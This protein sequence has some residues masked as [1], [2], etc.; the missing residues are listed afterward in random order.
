MSLPSTQTPLSTDLP[1]A[2]TF[3]RL[4]RREGFRVLVAIEPDGGAVQTRSFAVREESELAEWVERHNGDGENVYWTV[5]SVERPVAKKPSREDVAAMDFLHVDVDPDKRKPLDEERARIAR[6]F[7]TRPSGVPVPTLL[8]DSGGG[9][10]AFWRLESPFR[11]E[12]S[13][14]LY[15]DAKRYNQ[16]LEVLFGGDACHNVDRIMRLPGTVNWPDARKRAAGRVPRLAALLETRDVAYP[17]SA[18]TPAPRV[19]SPG[20]G[21]ALPAAR[22]ETSNVRRLLSLEEL[23]SSATGQ[24]KVVINQGRDP[25]NPNKWPSRSEPLFWVCCELIRIGVADDVIYSV[26]TDPDFGI[27]ESVLEKGA[28]SERYALQQIAHAHDHVTD[29]NLAEL[30]H[31]HAVIGDLG[32]KCRIL[33]EGRDES[34]DRP[35]LSYQSFDDFVNRYSNRTAIVG[36]GDTERRVPL[37]KWWITHPMRRT[38]E[39][40][41]FAPGRDVPDSYNLWR[42]FTCE[43]IPGDCTLYLRHIQENICGGDPTLYDYVLSWMASAVQDPGRPGQVA[44]VLRG[45]RGAGKGVFAQGLGALFGRHFMQVTN[46]IQ[47]VGQ[48]NHHLKDCVVL[49]A[50]E[51]FYAG[52]KRHEAVLKSLVT[53]S[54]IMTEAKYQSAEMARN[55]LHLIMAANSDWVVPAGAHERRFLVLDVGNGNLQDKPFFGAV[56]QQL[57]AGGHEALLHELMTRSLSGFQPREAPRTAALQEQKEHSLSLEEEWWYSKLRA[58]EVRD[59]RGWPEWIACSELLFDFSHHA[60]QW[61]RGQRSSTVRIGRLLEKAGLSRKQLGRRV[62]VLT[63]AGELRSVD[64][65]RVYQL[66]PLEA[67]RATWGK[68]MGGEFDWGR[69][70]VLK[71]GPEEEPYA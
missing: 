20:E 31:K 1:A 18:F 28:R 23:P 2:L 26:I 16:Q 35:M 17:L 51:A 13:P 61:G 50:D 34:L 7:Q 49:F 55:C 38:F 12:G 70:D 6:L 39:R 37:G 47:L 60:Q 48:F 57:E 30:N 42:G 32:G 5:N 3:L 53:E 64:R 21:F 44:L 29:P 4:T 11:I 43:A 62:E 19:Q 68:L 69:L 46:P 67:A 33:S 15:E 63:E 36:S 54:H 58:G 71:D 10:Q 14:E 56:E 45:T 66:P 24:L 25:D 8:V 40:V 22:V 59:S 65:P 52:D 9:L 41:V 27:S